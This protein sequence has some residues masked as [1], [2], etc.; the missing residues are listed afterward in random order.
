M[1]WRPINT[2]DLADRDEVDLWLNI[3]ASP[4][5]MGMS[6]S[7]RV[8]DAYRIDG[9]WLHRVESGHERELHLDY[10]THWMRRPPPPRS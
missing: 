7:F 8:I 2:F 5:S 10:I 6:D 9:K 4:R 3:H 1:T